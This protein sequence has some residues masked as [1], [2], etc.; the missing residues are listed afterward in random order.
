M[1]EKQDFCMKQI[2][3]ILSKNKAT[4]GSFDKGLKGEFPVKSYNGILNH[5]KN[6]DYIYQ[7]KVILKMATK[8]MRIGIE[9]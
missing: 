4:Y 3:Y 8:E 6:M 9:R 2:L 1:K 5:Y 7:M